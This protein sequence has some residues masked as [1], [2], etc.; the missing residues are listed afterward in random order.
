MALP[1]ALYAKNCIRK[2]W[3]KR[4]R[5]GAEDKTVVRDAVLS[6][7][8]HTKGRVL[9]VLCEAVSPEHFAALDS[10]AYVLCIRVTH[11]PSWGRSV[12]C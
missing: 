4:G 11:S 8:L 1:A 9:R 10:L 2:E 12:R 3:G 6:C 5:L 7:A